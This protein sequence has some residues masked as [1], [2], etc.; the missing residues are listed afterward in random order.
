MN[1]VTGETSST[2]T[3][4]S[5]RKAR[6]RVKTKEKTDDAEEKA[7]EEAIE[8]EARTEESRAIKEVTTMVGTLRLAWQVDLELSLLLSKARSPL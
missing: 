5:Y 2:R 1:I 7:V 8:A 6:V 3:V 4:S